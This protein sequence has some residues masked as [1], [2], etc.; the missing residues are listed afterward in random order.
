MRTM[1]LST[2]FRHF[3]VVMFPKAIQVIVLSLVLNLPR[4]WFNRLQ[5]PH[6]ACL[7]KVDERNG[8]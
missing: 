8:R 3:F 4:S 6:I 2:W 7:F 5:M 1:I